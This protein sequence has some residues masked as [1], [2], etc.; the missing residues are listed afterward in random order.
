MGEA[1]LGIDA[2]WTRGN[3]SGV[4]L[5]GR[6]GT[7]WRCLALAPSYAAFHA[8]AQGEAVDWADR[9]RG[10]AP[11]AAALLTTCRALGAE[12]VSAVAVDMPLAL[13]EITG[14]READR[15]LSRALGARGCS[16]HSPTPDRPGAISHTLRDGFHAA[17]FQLATGAT[18]RGTPGALLEVYP[19]AALLE[20][21][22]LERR[23]EYKTSRARR[24]WP[25]LSGPQRLPRLLDA[26]G[27][28]L[29]GL[30]RH[31]SGIELPLPTPDEVRSTAALKPYEDALDALVCA[32][33]GAKF[34]EGRAAAYGDEEAAIWV[35]AQAASSARF[36]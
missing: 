2:A 10:E 20:L 28:I 17:G 13:G 19:H 12:T 36:R 33:V 15:A 14:Y 7:G 25:E 6:E 27:R 4:A 16:V 11:D 23:L 22:G 21:L 8:L 35:P 5:I 3:P 31:I 18:R 34:L 9:P 29:R 30:R 1:I 24:F 26:F 32:W